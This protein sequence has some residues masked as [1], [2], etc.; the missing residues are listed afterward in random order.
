V[1]RHRER[2]ALPSPG[3]GWS[4]M[5]SSQ[6]AR[7]LFPPGVAARSF[8]S[9]HNLFPCFLLCMI[10]FFVGPTPALTQDGSPQTP[11][12]SPA[13]Q[14][15]SKPNS[16]EIASH[17]EPTT[18]KVNVKLVVVR[19]VVRDSQGHAVGNLHQEDFQVFDKG[20][21]QVI[22]QFDVEQPGALTAKSRQTSNENSGDHLTAIRLPILGMRRQCPS[23]LWLTCSTTCIC[24]SAISP[25][26]VRPRNAT[27]PH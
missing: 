14:V 10:W 12:P 26:S 7:R 1:A 3:D 5:R 18:F 15:E 22:T 21:P 23:V 9:A 17:D 8:F 19:A 27:L 11:A 4:F 2:D 6:E 16:A 25:R 24:N 13:P 20:K